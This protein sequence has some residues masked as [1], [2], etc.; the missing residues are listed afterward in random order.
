LTTPANPLEPPDIHY[1][2]AAQG[3]LELGNW[4]EANDELDHV[5]P[6]LRGH[7]DVLEVRFH[8]WAAAA[9]WDA[10]ADMARE[11]IRANPKEAQFWIS[12][13]YATRRM[14]GGGIP[15]AAEI[16]REAR[17]IFST[18]PLIAYNLACYDCQL[19]NELEAE[20]WL[21]VAFDLGDA[22]KIKSMAL[23]DSDLKPLWSRI[24]KLAENAAVE[25]SK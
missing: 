12:H 20:N 14:P 22:E 17:Q 19:G 7:P 9:K 5:A 10:A 1:A 23:K 3:W 18:E 24:A 13:A 16:L 4:R 2:R 11:L 15:Q 8:I 25:K 21:K 6:S